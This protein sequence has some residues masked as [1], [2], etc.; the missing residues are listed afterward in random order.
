MPAQTIFMLIRG[1]ESHI[2]EA[3]TALDIHGIVAQPSERGSGLVE[4]W[5]DPPMW[6]PTP[7]FECAALSRATEGV[8]GTDFIATELGW[9]ETGALSSYVAVHRDT[10]EPLGFIDNRSQPVEARALLLGEWL[11]RVDVPVEEIRWREVAD[12]DPGSNA[13]S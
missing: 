8:A 4:A 3:L 11:S 10:G 1:P 9:Q 7:E 6:P 5:F 12:L 2:G 13:S